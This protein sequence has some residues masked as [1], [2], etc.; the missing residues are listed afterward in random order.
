MTIGL[1]SAGVLACLAAG[2]GACGGSGPTQA[3]D[4]GTTVATGSTTTVPANVTTTPVVATTASSPTTLP[5]AGGPVPAGFD[6]VSFTAI[7]DSDYWLLGDAPCNNPVCTSIVRTTDGGAHFV[8]LPAPTAPLDIGKTTSGINTLRF[9][10]AMDGYAYAIGAGGAFWDTHDGGGQWSQPPALSGKQ[11]LGFGTGAGYA[12]AL[13]GACSQQSGSCSGLAL[14]RSPVTT[15][16]WSALGLPLSSA[17][18]PVSFSVRG[19]DLWL[20]IAAPSDEGHQSLLVSSSSGS[21]FT[22]VSSPCFAGFGGQLQATSAEVVWALCPTGMMAEA[23]RSTD[24][25]ATWHNLSSGSSSAA[26]EFE[27]S[28]LLAPANDTTALLGPASQGKLL[29]TTDGGVT[30]QDVSTPA[31]GYWSWMGFTDPS[32]GS[33]LLQLSSV[34]AGWPWPNGPFPEQLWRTSDGGS[35]WSGPVAFS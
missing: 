4:T 34:P 1:A 23:L 33:A 8:G 21:S 12:L 13:T 15:D 24:G 30:W 18:G 25:G 11:L 20:S 14:V 2:L 17:S 19:P 26:A 16:H 5:A 3:G 31:T 22:S 27:N 9:A 29:R 7:S 6:P 28:A 32:T 10:D 35:T